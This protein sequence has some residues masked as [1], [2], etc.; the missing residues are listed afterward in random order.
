MSPTS[1]LLFTFVIVGWRQKSQTTPSKPLLRSE[2]CLV[3]SEVK[4]IDMA[5]RYY[6]GQEE[7]N[8]FFSF[9]LFERTGPLKKKKH[10]H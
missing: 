6:K 10:F 3:L 1:K 4:A 9:D 5:S 7:E 8:V 2:Q